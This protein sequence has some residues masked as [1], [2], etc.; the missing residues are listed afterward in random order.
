MIGSETEFQRK[1]LRWYRR[2][3]RDL[4]WRT[5]LLSG[6]SKSSPK[7][8]KDSLP[9]PYHVLVSEAMLQQTQVA[10]VISYFQRFIARWPTLADLAAADEQEVLKLWAGL[11]YYSRARNLHRC[12]QKIVEQFGGDV[13]HKVEVLLTLP[14]V[15]RYTAGAIASLAFDQHAAIVDGNVIRVI[16]RLDRIE[17][18]PR[19]SSMTMEA[20]WQR[21]QAILPPRHCGDFNSALMELGATV[22][23]PQNPACLTCPVR[24]HC[25]AADDGVQNQIPPPRQRQP[26]PLHRRW[27]FCIRRGQRYLLQRRPLRGRWGGL[28]QFPT[29]EADG[30]RMSAAAAASKLIGE[31]VAVVHPMGSINHTLTHRRYEFEVFHI[32]SAGREMG[33]DGQWL[34]LPEIDLQPLS[35]PQQKI[36]KML[37]EIPMLTA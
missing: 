4:P 1:L 3:R 28:W 5:P 31:P 6:R 32:S 24:T 23:R 16:C 20:V 35:R 25:Q 12:A 13:P 33:A 21:A 11:G 22:C 18:D 10:T 37:D 34:T 19:T 2:H 17:T 36:R 29:V 26:S 8:S 14:G 15:G 27:T 7:P 30:D 9:S